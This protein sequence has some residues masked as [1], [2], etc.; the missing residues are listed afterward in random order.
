MCVAPP[1]CAYLFRFWGCFALILWGGFCLPR[2]YAQSSSLP[3][4]RARVTIVSLPD[5]YQPA[6]PALKVLRSDQNTPLRAGTVWI[7]NNTPEEQP[8]AY[9]DQL[10]NAG[11]NAV[12]MVLFDTWMHENNYTTVRWTQAAYRASMLQKI[13][14]AVDHASARGLYVIINSHNGYGLYDAT[15]VDELWTVVAPRYAARTHVLYEAANEPLLT[16]GNN[17]DTSLVQPGRLAAVKTTYNLIRAAAPDT[18]ILVLSPAN[19]LSSPASVSALGNLADHFSALPGTVDWTK[20]SVAYHLYGGHPGLFPQAQDLRNFHARYPGWPSENNFPSSVSSQTLGITDPV[21]S[22]AYA[23][24]PYI[25]QTAEFLGTGWSLWNIN[26]VDQFARNWPIM[27][28]DAQA[29]G[30]TWTVDS[31]TASPEA[32]HP[33]G[34][35]FNSA[36]SVT[37]TCAT[38]GATIRYTVDGS[39]PS[40]SVGLVYTGPLLIQGDTNLHAIA[41]GV[42]LAASALRTWTYTLQIASPVADY[43]AGS[44]FNTPTSIALSTT[45][46]GAQIRYTLDYTGPSA[47]LGTLYTGPIPIDSSF[48]NIYAVAYY[49]GGQTSPLRSWYYYYQVAEVVP[50]ISSGTTLTTPTSLTLSSETSGAIIRYTLDGTAPSASQGFTYTLPLLLSADTVLN[51]VAIATNGDLSSEVN[52]VYFY[53]T[54]N[55]PLGINLGGGAL[56]GFGAEGVFESPSEPVIAPPIPVDTTGVLYA[57]PPALYSTARQAT[58]NLAVY[59]PPLAP[60]KFYVLRLHFAEHEFSTPGARLLDFTADHAPIGSSGFE[61]LTAADGLMNRASVLRIPGLRTRPGETRIRIGVDSQTAAP[62]ILYG[63]EFIPQTT[64]EDIWRTQNFT[65]AQL[66]DLAIG[67]WTAAPAGDGVSHLHK[68]A[69]NLVGSGPDQVMSPLDFYHH[70]LIS[71]GEAG[72][73]RLSRDEEYGSLILTYIRRRATPERP[74]FIRYRVQTNNDLTTPWRDDE[75]YENLVEPI[76]DTWERVTVY[77][78]YSYLEGRRFIRVFVTLNPGDD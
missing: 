42:G 73:P 18:H 72:L 50:S 8:E 52:Q 63:L 56:P 27:L 5:A 61:P 62:A 43:P 38:A 28:A 60:D 13:D 15:W 66:A 76:S 25:N 49:P 31:Q 22:I 12:R 77:D 53:D 2:L 20:T 32:S 40:P 70:T 69:F 39:I 24:H 4:D 57:G 51:T 67:A 14:R 58:P 34:T 71:D 74:S 33:D 45:S 11:L 10:K 75:T 48:V 54:P 1:S 29:R 9:Y 7:W 64:A 36:T 21:R 26:G 23:D 55:P 68:F 3:T 16:L 65:P 37:L 46:I 59:S 35:I 44:S 41:Y 78:Y 6:G 47:T 19:I 30:W 17:G